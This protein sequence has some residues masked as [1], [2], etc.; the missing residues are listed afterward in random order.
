MLLDGQLEKAL[1]YSFRQPEL[2]RQALTHSSLA[3]ERGVGSLHN[4]QLEFLGDSVLGFLVSTRLLERFPGYSE[5]QLSKLK[6]HLVSATFLLP[7]AGQLDL[8]GYLQLGRGEERSGGRSKRAVLVNALEALIAALYLDGGIEAARRFVDEFVL[9]DRLEKG[10]EAFPFADYK[11][12]LQEYL[13]AHKRAQPRYV[14][15]EERGPEHRKVFLIEVRVGRR[16]VAQAEGST[17]KNAEQAAAQ[18]ALE[19][20][21]AEKTAGTDDDGNHA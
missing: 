5:G 13:Q 15:V 12:T 9:G 18:A 21:Q 19:K 2:L 6:A 11:S 20:L 14:V 10:I 8:G 7:V 4:E 3:H 1:G 17:K 16:P